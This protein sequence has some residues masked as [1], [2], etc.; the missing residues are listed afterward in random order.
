[1]GPVSPGCTVFL[2]DTASIDDIWRWFVR[3][4]VEGSAPAPTEEPVPSAA[5]GE[6]GHLFHVSYSDERESWTYL[7]NMGNVIAEASLDAEIGAGAT[8]DELMAIASAIAHRVEA[9]TSGS[10]LPAAPSPTPEPSFPSEAE[11]ALLGHVPAS[12]RETCARTDYAVSEDALAA[13]ACTA[14]VGEG[15]ATVTYQQLADQ[16]ALTR[17]HERFMEVQRVAPDSGACSGE[18]PAEG[19]YTIAGEEAG[20]VACADIGGVALFM[21]WTDDRLLIHGFAEGFDTDPATLYGWWLTES[22]PIG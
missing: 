20:R 21:S 16:E 14:V 10:P 3:T 17:I 5:P 12:F 1:M 15:S 8:V 6:D 18:W 19:S 13:V 9:A 7:F 4:Y 22:G 11:T 2:F